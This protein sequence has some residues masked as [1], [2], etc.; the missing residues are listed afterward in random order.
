MSPHSAPALPPIYP[1]N[2]NATAG[3]AQLP[4]QQQQAPPP[5]RN[6]TLD[7]KRPGRIRDEKGGKFRIVIGSCIGDG[8]P[9]CDCDACLATPPEE[10]A[11]N[12]DRGKNHNYRAR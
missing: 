12:K 2:P 8:P 1:S 5:R 10:R 9:G 7:P 11:K 6:L 4:P 3:A